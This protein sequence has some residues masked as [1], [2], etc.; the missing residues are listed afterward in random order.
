[1]ATLSE[2]RKADR[3]RMAKELVKTVMECGAT[4]EVLE[5]GADTYRPRRVLIA[6]E[7]PRG[8]CCGI[9]FD[10]ETIQ[11]N[12]FVNGWNMSTR[13]DAC[14]AR[15]RF[16]DGEVNPHHQR[17]CTTVVRGFDALLEHVRTVLTRAADGSLFDAEKEAQHVAENGTWQD[18]AASFAKWREELRA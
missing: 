3:A 17:K 11:P 2:T 13:T 18:R 9:D 14:L 7:G 15:G 6:I 8:L 1:M 16:P 4:C 10:G 5:E 12:I